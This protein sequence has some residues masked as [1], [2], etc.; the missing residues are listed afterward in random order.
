MTGMNGPGPAA[1][2]SNIRSMATAPAANG[3][4]N[5]SRIEQLMQYR[6]LSSCFHSNVDPLHRPLTFI[7]SS[8]RAM[9]DN[10]KAQLVISGRQKLP[11]ASVHKAGIELRLL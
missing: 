8:C 9:L 11:L 5:F 6:I 1:R 2:L 4:R 7:S 10:D 3:H